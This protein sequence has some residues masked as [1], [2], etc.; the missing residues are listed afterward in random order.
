VEETPPGYKETLAKRLTLNFPSFTGEDDTPVVG[1]KYHIA[2]YGRFLDDD[3]S[4]VIDP[5]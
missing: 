2:C 1:R 5:P 3:G 4:G